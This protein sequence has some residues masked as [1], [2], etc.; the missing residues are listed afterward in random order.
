MR[1]VVY[2]TLVAAVIASFFWG[3]WLPA[4]VIG[5]V[6]ATLVGIEYMEL[7]HAHP[8]HGTAFVL[9]VVAVVLTLSIVGMS[10]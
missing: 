10:S 5:G 1:F 4:L 6:K 8:L 3:L 7:R 9:G 2:L